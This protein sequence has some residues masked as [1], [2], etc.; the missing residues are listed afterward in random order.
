MRSMPADYYLGSARHRA[1]SLG[2]IA[3]SLARASRRVRDELMAMVAVNMRLA[4][5]AYCGSVSA[6]RP[7]GMSLPTETGTMAENA[8]KLLIPPTPSYHK[9]LI[10]PSIRLH[11]CRQHVRRH[12]QEWRRRRS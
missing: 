1:V 5:N 2:R 4:P 11:F 7:S 6:P 8:T 3:E 9:G 12:E 10:E